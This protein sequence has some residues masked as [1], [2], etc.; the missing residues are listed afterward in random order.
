MVSDFVHE[1]NGYLSFISK[2]EAWDLM[3]YGANKEGYWSSD[4]FL[5]QMEKAIEIA[6]LIT[7]CINMATHVHNFTVWDEPYRE[8]LKLILHTGKLEGI[9]MAIL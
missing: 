2:R 4:K 1:Q 6:D 7:Y 8:M 3:E 9:C 5:Q